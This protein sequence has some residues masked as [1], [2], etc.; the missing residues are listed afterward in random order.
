[1]SAGS[2][3]HK[4]NGVLDVNGA[5]DVTGALT[6]ATGTFSGLITSKDLTINSA[7]TVGSTYIYQNYIRAASIRVTDNAY[8]G[9]QSVPSV[10]QIQGDGDVAIGYPLSGT[11][12]TFSGNIATTGTGT[13]TSASSLT[14]GGALYVD[15]N[16]RHTGDTNNYHNFDTD[17]QTFFT[18]GIAAL[19]IDSGQNLRAKADSDT[20]LLIHGGGADGTQVFTDSSPSGHTISYFGAAQWDDTQSK[21]ASTSIKFDGSGDYLSVENHADLDFGT[22]DFTIDF[23]ANVNSDSVQDDTFFSTLPSGASPPGLC[24]SIR[25]TGF[26]KKLGIYVNGGHIPSA[27]TSA[28]INHSTWHHIALVRVGGTFN[29]YVDGVNVGSDATNGSLNL[30]TDQPLVL[31][32]FY[33][34]V[35]NYYLHGYIEEFRISK[36][37]ARW[38]S[39]FTPPARP[40]S[41]VNDEFF[42]DYENIAKSGIGTGV[43]QTS[44][45]GN[46]GVGINAFG[47]E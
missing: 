13:I 34:D 5:L 21:F 37:I 46:L 47:L 4:V 29:F 6:G 14:A 35:D 3:D 11:S 28:V 33:T 39:D 38:T 41:T 1:M 20:K 9:C 23:W 45:D 10:I 30:D 42:N 19:T 43:I 31:G 27:Y 8:L 22:A 44:A 15:E 16:I 24:M 40:Y 26:P 17:T 25:G 12:A 18:G 2:T 7:I 36:G 32:R